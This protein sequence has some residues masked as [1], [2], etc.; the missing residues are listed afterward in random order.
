M[1]KRRRADDGAGR[2]G[3][4]QGEEDRAGAATTTTQLKLSPELQ[5]K[6]EGRKYCKPEELSKQLCIDRLSALG[7]LALV[8]TMNVEIQMLSS[9]TFSLTMESTDNSVSRLKKDIEDKQG[10]KSHLQQ[11][12]LVPDKK[13][14]AGGG[15]DDAEVALADDGMIGGHCCVLLCIRVETGLISSSVLIAF[16][17]FIP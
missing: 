11:L 5:A 4:G 14:G 10:A 3:A 6:M 1:V 17:V 16:S 13:S 9:D 15:S 8:V 2:E 7:E 12:Y